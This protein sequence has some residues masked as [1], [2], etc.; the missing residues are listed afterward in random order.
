M[1]L[2]ILLLLAIGCASFNN[3]VSNTLSLSNFKLFG[4]DNV[5]DN[6]N[7][8]LDARR[9]IES[10]KEKVSTNLSPNVVDLPSLKGYVDTMET[11]SAEGDFWDDTEAAQSMLAELNLLKAQVERATKWELG[12]ADVSDLIEMAQMEPEQ[13]AAYL[14][15][16]EK[17]LKE[18]EKDLD[19]FEV[20]RLL[21]GKYDQYPCIINIQSGAGGTEAQD[22]AGMLLRMYRRYAE[23][24]GFKITTIEENK[25]D[26]GIKSAE[27]QI[28]GSFAYGYL[29]GEK[30]THRLVRISPFN[31]QG[32]RQTSF[33]GVETYPLLPDK[34]VDNIEIPESEVEISTMRA[35]GAGGQ[36]V[37]KVET[38]VRIKHIPTGIMI[39]C[40]SERS[41]L[42]N[43]QEAWKRLKAKLAAIALENAME[44]FQELRGDTVEATFGQQIRNYVFAPYKMVKDTRTAHETPQ[45]QDV[46]D[47]DLDEF[48]TAYLRWNAE[49]K[50]SE[51]K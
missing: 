27:L 9:R 23:R 47:G 46:M 21:G 31:S 30:G 49:K 25:E 15:E 3:I 1:R 37:N 5:V 45:T 35:G 42:A 22:W 14:T 32:K 2:I 50:K 43:R 33:A 8:L 29:A 36:N 10:L 51:V 6:P 7:A 24:K 17:I 44:D 26:F 13:E 11:R 28:D 39:K 34:E 12:C 40:T 16:A 38:A 20:E 18:V 4:E 19:M 41:Q 48:I